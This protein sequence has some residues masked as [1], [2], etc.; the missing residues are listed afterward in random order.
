MVRLHFMSFGKGN[1]FPTLDI[2]LLY[3]V[4]LSEL[5]VPSKDLLDWYTVSILHS[6]PALA[7]SLQSQDEVLLPTLLLLDSAIFYSF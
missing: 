7:L 6:F 1:G 2:P 5:P 4:D 3:G